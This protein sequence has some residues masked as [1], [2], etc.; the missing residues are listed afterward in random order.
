MSSGRVL[1]GRT[2]S[3]GSRRFDRVCVSCDFRTAGWTPNR[4]P[5]C[6][7]T[8]FRET[9]GPWL[10]GAAIRSAGASVR[11]RGVR[12]MLWLMVLLW[13]LLVAAAILATS[14]ALSGR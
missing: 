11:R 3:R 7:A 6:G 10:G 14:P 13:I 9:E 12:P 8:D 4:C 1:T 5:L 2:R